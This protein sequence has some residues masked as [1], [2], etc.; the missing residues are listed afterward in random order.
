MPEVLESFLIAIN[1]HMQGGFLSAQIACFVWGLVSTFLSPCHMASI[2][3]LVSYAAGQSMTV[4][5]KECVRYALLFSLGLF[6]SIALIGFVCTLLGS[7]LGEVP[8]ILYG[9]FALLLIGVGLR[10]LLNNACAIPYAPLFSLPLSGYTGAFVIGLVY[11]LLSGV[12]T[13]GFLAPILTVLFI[14]GELV[15][16]VCTSLAFAAGHCLPIVFLGS[17]VSF[18]ENVGYR[19]VSNLLKRLAGLLIVGIGGYYLYLALE[20]L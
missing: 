8:A 19:R 2:P 14:E 11:G 6:V 15:R 10:T 13:F 5:P 1:D 12:C 16:G 4:R 17:G 20:K 18:L 3:L 9:L 7:L